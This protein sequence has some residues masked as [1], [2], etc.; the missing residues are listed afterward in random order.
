MKYLDNNDS[1]EVLLFYHGIQIRACAFVSVK[2]ECF[3]VP[4]VPCCMLREYFP[5]C[6]GIS[7]KHKESTGEVKHSI[8]PGL[9]W[10]AEVGVDD[11]LASWGSVPG[12]SV[13]IWL[14]YFSSRN[15]T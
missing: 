12:V 7:G 5:L 4:Y 15:L 14:G 6:L 2:Q 9:S 10:C 11:L 8:C 1:W 3:Y 13:F